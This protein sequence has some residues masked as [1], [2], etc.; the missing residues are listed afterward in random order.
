M[1]KHYIPGVPN[2]KIVTLA[3]FD[4]EPAAKEFAKS[5]SKELLGGDS[6][7]NDREQ[8]YQSND[9]VGLRCQMIYVFEDC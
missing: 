3:S 7:W 5:K 1:V 9:I 6:F 4:N 2:D 8:S